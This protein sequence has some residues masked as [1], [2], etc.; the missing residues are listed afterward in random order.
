MGMGNWGSIRIES[1]AMAILLTSSSA[2][3]SVEG[4]N[5]C[6]AA[7]FD[8]LKQAD[9][10]LTKQVANLA[11]DLPKLDLEYVRKNFILPNHRP[12]DEA[13]P[14]NKR[15]ENYLRSMSQGLLRLNV[16]IREGVKVTCRHA[17]LDPNCR[18]GEVLAYVLFRGN[19][20]LKNLYFCSGFFDQTEAQKESTFFHELTHYTLA[21]EDRGLDWL[22]GPATNIAMAPKDAYH[23]ESLVNSDVESSLKRQI[24]YWNWPKK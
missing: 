22:E 17:K 12:W 3:A 24:W 2:M 4:G 15:Y 16:D 5:G 8:A 14:K 23:W 6:S 9:A 11:S 1:W 21:T 20:P 7:Q 13:S 19:T 18:G 10:S